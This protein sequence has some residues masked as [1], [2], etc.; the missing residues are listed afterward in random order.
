MTFAGGC[1]SVSTTLARHSGDCSS[2]SSRGGA[3]LRTERSL[4]SGRTERRRRC[5]GF[6]VSPLEGSRPARR[7]LALAPTRTGKRKESRVVGPGTPRAEREET[8]TPEDSASSGS[9]YFT[10]C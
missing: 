3:A 7:P 6:S 8:G 1:K 9:V 10:I 5:Y 2:G 4:C